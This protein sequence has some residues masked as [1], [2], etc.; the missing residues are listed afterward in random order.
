MFGRVT[1]GNL[2]DEG[3]GKLLLLACSDFL[4]HQSLLY[5]SDSNMVSADPS[6]VFAFPQ[7]SS[8]VIRGGRL[9][10]QDPTFYSRRTAGMIATPQ[11]TSI[12]GPK[13]SSRACIIDPVRKRNNHSNSP[14]RSSSQTSSS[15][16]PLSRFSSSFRILFK[17]R[18][19]APSE[20]NSSLAS[21]NS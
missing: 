9:D 1:N 7:L 13:T 5:L 16:I 2:H 15:F 19:I 3:R 8:W 14:N 12:V 6:N 11:T 17:N 10:V 4:N 20:P 21:L 18:S